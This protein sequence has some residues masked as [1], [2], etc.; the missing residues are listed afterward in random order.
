MSR[1]GAVKSMYLSNQSLFNRRARAL[2]VSPMPWS[3]GVSR[4]ARELRGFDS[5]TCARY[6]LAAMKG[7]PTG[8]SIDDA[9]QFCDESVVAAYQHR[10]PYP[11]ELFSILRQLAVDSPRAVLDIGC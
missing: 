2:P 6:R 7:K 8:L 1:P 10:P 11:P 9:R 4:A 5:T 3:G